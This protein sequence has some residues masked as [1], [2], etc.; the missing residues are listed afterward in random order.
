MQYGR[1]DRA[2]RLLVG[3]EHDLTPMSILPAVGPVEGK[4]ADVYRF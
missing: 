4:Y 1:G 2:L 3:D